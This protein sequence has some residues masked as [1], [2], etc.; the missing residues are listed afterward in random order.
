MTTGITA[1]TSNAATAGTAT[2]AGTSSSNGTISETDFLQLFTT[3]LQ[4]QDPLNP[5]DSDQLTS[6]LAQ[7]SEV[8]AMTNVN[9][10]MTN[11][12]Q[13]QSSDLI[14]KDVQLTDGTTQTVTGVVFSNN[15][16]YFELGDGSTIQLGN[17]E[18]IQ[19]G[20]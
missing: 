17:I 14:G 16:T 2:T 10:Q 3:Q 5:M 13:L 12:L 18:S 9:S 7:F 11:L 1:A 19:G 8:E 6:E 15:Q 4:D 20:S